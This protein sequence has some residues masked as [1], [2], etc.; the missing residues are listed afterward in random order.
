MPTLFETCSEILSGLQRARVANQTKHEV[1]A[2]QQRLKEW[3]QIASTRATLL[4]KCSVVNPDLLKQEEIASDDTQVRALVSKARKILEDGG[5]VLALSDENL[6]VRLI[7]QAEGSNERYR[8]AAK[9][10][11]RSFIE[12][13][14]HIELPSKVEAR[15][16]KT[17]DNQALLNT[18]KQHFNSA[19]GIMRAELPASETDKTELLSSVKSIQ[20]LNVQL[21]SFAPEAV[22]L[23]LQTVQTGGASLTMAT[24]EVLEWIRTHDDLDRFVVKPKGMSTWR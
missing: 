14:G 22:R 7:A 10:E 3:S 18:Y 17:P 16:L 1:S 12:N 13:L 24:T 6:W 11:W 9:R 15:M 8:T 4:T 2:L 20:D 23:F 21:K 5:N 19:Q